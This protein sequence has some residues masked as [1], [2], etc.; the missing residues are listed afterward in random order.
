MDSLI[1]SKNVTTK[2]NDVSLNRKQLI[3]DQINILAELHEYQS[4]SVVSNNTGIKNLIIL[5]SIG[6]IKMFK[7]Q[8]EINS[9]NK[10]VILVAF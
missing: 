2:Q 3:I 4:S 8:E 7:R 1:L 6:I 10:L 9:V 5:E